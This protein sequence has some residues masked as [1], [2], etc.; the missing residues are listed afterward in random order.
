MK[1]AYKLIE[2]YY[3]SPEIGTIIREDN[4][5]QLVSEE[6][7]I[8]KLE[9]ILKCKQWIE[10]VEEN[11]VGFEFVNK[12]GHMN[13]FECFITSKIYSK[14]INNY[15]IYNYCN[16]NYVGSSKLKIS[17]VN[18]LIEIGNWIQ[19]KPKKYFVSCDCADGKC[20]H[21]SLSLYYIDDN[22]IVR[23]I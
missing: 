20:D 8:F 23:W 18:R 21:T 14:D 15:Q 4:L 22:N 1:K 11:Y 6:L 13:D 7:E 19:T 17:F 10:I 12:Y 16:G 9:E 3:D 2:K 5:G